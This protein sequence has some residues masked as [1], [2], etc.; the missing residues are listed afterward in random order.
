MEN[1]TFVTLW[2][3][4]LYKVMPFGLKNSGATYQ[5]DMV[6]LFHDIIHH[7]IEVYIDDMIV[8][9]QTKEEH[10]DHLHK[11]FERLKKYKLRLYPNKCTFGVSSGKLL[12]FVISGKGI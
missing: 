7:E 4:F 9:S 2:G 11:L 3:T 1:T 5:R 10:L 6:A 12:G 8:R